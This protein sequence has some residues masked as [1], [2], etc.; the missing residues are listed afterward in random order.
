MCRLEEELPTPTEIIQTL[1]I[2]APKGS[3]IE[4]TIV[5]MQLATDLYEARLT[6]SLVQQEDK[7]M[8]I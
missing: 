5:A 7:E 6:P 8:N 2:L 1:N 3:P 4:Q